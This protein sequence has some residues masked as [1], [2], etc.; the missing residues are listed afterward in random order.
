MTERELEQY[1]GKLLD[2]KMIFHVKGN[3]NGLKGYPDRLVFSDKIYFCEV[4]LG[5]SEGSYYKQTAM[6]K[7][8]QDKIEKS[9]G[10]YIL[11]TGKKEIE[12]FVEK[13]KGEN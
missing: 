4:K 12:D 1:M 6:Q 13:L 3:P 2:K 8:W 7:W 10:V 11:L 5:K 9:N